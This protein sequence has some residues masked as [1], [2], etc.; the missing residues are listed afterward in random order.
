M[1][2]CSP[3]WIAGVDGCRAGWLGVFLEVRTGILRMRTGDRL[4][5]WLHEPEAPQFLAV[6]I[7]IGLPS[8]AHRGGRSC[9]REARRR[10]G[11]SRGS[12]VFS[13]PVRAT[14]SAEDYAS[15]L[16]VQR[17]S[18]E[19]RIGLSK[20]CYHLL[21]RI[22]EVDALVRR[23][24]QDCIR[25][26]HPELSFTAMNAGGQLRY[27]KHTSEG[28]S[29]RETLLRETGFEK[30]LESDLSRTPGAK[31]HDLLD[32]CVACWTARRI[33]NGEAERIPDSPEH[34]ACG[35]AMEIWF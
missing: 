22:R 34:D 3:I 23:V 14:L 16:A 17:S 31:R 7:P 26:V 20:Q 19:D 30:V 2:E 35:L 21:P 24:G 18:S 27:S 5:N 13:A 1:N 12:S 9:D 8:S 4:A 32:A 6:D 15:A 33:L 29:L 11:P 28:V 25:E 10:L